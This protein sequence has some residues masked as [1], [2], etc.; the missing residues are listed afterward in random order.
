MRSGN[1]FLS[2][3]DLLW[4]LDQWEKRGRKPARLIEVLNMDNP[5][6]PVSILEHNKRLRRVYREKF[7][8]L[9]QWIK[10]D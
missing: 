6:D 3:R 5:K 8:G 4:E 9:Q 7:P 1:E 2:M 10:E